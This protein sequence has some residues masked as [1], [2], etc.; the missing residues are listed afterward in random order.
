M[1]GNV[2]FALV[3]TRGA[4]PIAECASNP[5]GS[6]GPPHLRATAEAQTFKVH[7]S[8]PYFIPFS[9]LSFISSC[10][11]LL[12]YLVSHSS[13]S[14]TMRFCRR[15]CDDALPA[16]GETPKAGDWLKVRR[17]YIRSL[18]CQ[19]RSIILLL[20]LTEALK[21]GPLELVYAGQKGFPPPGENDYGVS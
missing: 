16:A 15:S 3:A 6:Y 1:V 11:G 20:A 12:H 9:L 14:L 17:F 13:R 19:T 4:A 21:K 8:Q 18:R 5:S 2:Q 7:L 10:H